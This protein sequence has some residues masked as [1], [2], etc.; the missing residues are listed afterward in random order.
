[1]VRHEPVRRRTAAAVVVGVVAGAALG[2]CAGGGIASAAPSEPAAPIARAAKTINVNQSASLRLVRKSGSV[3]HERGTAT[4]TLP[5]AVTARF[6]VS[7]LKV[8]GEVTFLPRGGGSIT[9]AVEGFPRSTGSTAR[10]SGTMS[11]VRG[12]GRYARARGGATFNGVVN[13][14]TW[15]A[16]VAAVGRM[17]Y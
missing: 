11:I 1:M 10:F 2:L 14:R 16:S 8:T 12:S 3:L 13:R 6:V 17:R 4:G 7:S 5:G 15:A 9:F